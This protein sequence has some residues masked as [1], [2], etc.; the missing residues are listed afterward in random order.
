VRP[1][2]RFQ[3]EVGGLLVSPLGSSQSEHLDVILI[4]WIL[5]TSSVLGNSVLT[6][7]LDGDVPLGNNV[8]DG[9]PNTYCEIVLL[10]V[11]TDM[12]SSHWASTN[13]KEDSQ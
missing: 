9:N 8:D 11:Q 12:G 4:L 2:P 6:A 7:A 5:G 3:I 13:C 1:S 10:A